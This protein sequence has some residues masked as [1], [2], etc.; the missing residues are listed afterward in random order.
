[1]SIHRMIREWDQKIYIDQCKEVA[2]FPYN[3]NCAGF[4]INLSP[5]SL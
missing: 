2:T 5:R 4:E 1:M 3:N